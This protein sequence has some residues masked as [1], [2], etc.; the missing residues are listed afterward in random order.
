MEEKGVLVQRPRDKLEAEIN[1]FYV[2]EQDGRILI[3][4]SL[5]IGF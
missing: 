5:S 3:C 4:R 2:I 1:H